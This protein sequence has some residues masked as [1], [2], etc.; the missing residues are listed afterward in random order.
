MAL[1][2]SNAEPPTLRFGGSNA[3]II[4]RSLDVVAESVTEALRRAD[5]T[6]DQIRWLVP[7]QPN[8]PMLDQMIATVGAKHAEYV[9][10][11]HEHGSLGSAAIPVG[12]DAL[13]RTKDVRPGDRAL[14]FGVGG[15]ASYGAMVLEIDGAEGM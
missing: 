9:R 8:G 6:L 3:H 2:G 10:I 12:L 7:H 5:T 15:G 11:V 13:L 14:F 1:P 4:K